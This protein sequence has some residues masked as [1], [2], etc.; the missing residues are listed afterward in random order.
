MLNNIKNKFLDRLFQV[1]Q[2]TENLPQ[3][4]YLSSQLFCFQIPKK[5]ETCHIPISLKPNAVNLYI[6]NY[7]MIS[8]RSNNLYL[9]YHIARSRD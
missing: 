7:A 8:F 4:L 6:L 3:I 2:G 1:I 5:V 9:K